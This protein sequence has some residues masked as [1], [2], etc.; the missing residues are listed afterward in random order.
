MVKVPVKAILK[1]KN[2]LNILYCLL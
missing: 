2:T 1:N